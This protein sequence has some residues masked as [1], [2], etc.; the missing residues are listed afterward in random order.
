MPQTT[1]PPSFEMPRI[2]SLVKRV[3]LYCRVSTKEQALGFSMD[4]QEAD[5]I[6]HIE[7]NQYL[8]LFKVYRDPGVSGTKV[9]RP[10][11]DELREDIRNKFVDAVLVKAID[12]IGRSERVLMPWFWMLEEAGVDTISLTQQIDTTTGNGKFALSMYIAMAQAEWNAI[13]ERTVGGLNSKAAAG[14]WVCGVP[15]YG[16]TLEGRGSRGGSR[17][18]PYQPEVKVLLKA[19]DYLLVRGYS[20]ERAAAALNAE[21]YLTRSGVPWTGANLKLRILAILDGYVT[22]RNIAVRKG[23]PVQ[24]GPDGQ[25]KWGAT[26]KIPLP[27][28]LP[29]ATREGMRAFFNT[30]ARPRGNREHLYILSG[31]IK[32]TCGGRLVGRRR[33]LTETWMYGCEGHGEGRNKSVKGC[34]FYRAELIE[35]T[36]WKG[37][38]R[39]LGDRALLENAADDW[40]GTLPANGDDYRARIEE[41]DRKI[42]ENERLRT[43]SL[44]QYMQMGVDPIV[45]KA[46]QDRMEED[47]REL[48]T[49]RAVAQTLLSELETAMDRRA[50]IVALADVSPE[51]LLRLAPQYQ[52]QVIQILDLQVEVTADS[53]NLRLAHPCKI[54]GFFRESGRQVPHAL[55]DEQWDLLSSTVPEL[56]PRN[57][58]ISLRTVMDAGFYKVREDVR[59]NQLP[60]AYGSETSLRA[61]WLQWVKGDLLE[62]VAEALGVY[63]GTLVE[64]RELPEMRITGVLEGA[65]ASMVGQKE[66]NDVLASSAFVSSGAIQL[67][68]STSSTRAVPHFIVELSRS[69]A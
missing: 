24:L 48:Q 32:G 9:H 31:R 13:R 8:Q 22:F 20:P 47:V 62:R 36:I 69:A 35:E 26:Q 7:K 39:I 40:I 17:V 18:V 55:T 29:Q 19:A 61:I 10:G 6:A 21:G 3:A 30:R 25:P 16:Y 60:A 57:R 27:E 43:T 59:W 52:A 58:K 64:D 38:V 23:T 1:A 12:R 53:K 4:G 14:G 34:K 37:V 66:D 49:Q 56:S 63:E 68:A 41:L 46:A 2:E 44:I 33:T 65:L 45:V 51:R 28:I 11:L 50:Q 15:P 54:A 67:S 5:G 42:T